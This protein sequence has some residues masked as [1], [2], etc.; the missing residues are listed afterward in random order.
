MIKM[1]YK[2]FKILLLILI[3]VFMFQSVSYCDEAEESA[4]MSNLQY[5]KNEKQEK[6][7]YLKL[8]QY[9]MREEY[10]DSAITIGNELL[11]FKLSK[12]QKYNV[13]YNLATSYLLLSKNSS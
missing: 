12:K 6:K 4:L 11:R 1:F 9:Y 5:A 3:T 8:L 13:Y 2:K 7:A 10:Y